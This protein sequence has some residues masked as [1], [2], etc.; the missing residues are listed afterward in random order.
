MGKKNLFSSEIKRLQNPSAYAIDRTFSVSD[1]NGRDR[2]LIEK[3]YIEMDAIAR[4]PEWDEYWSKRGLKEPDESTPNRKF[5]YN[6]KE[7]TYGSPGETTTLDISTT[8]KFVSLALEKVKAELTRRS[9]L[10]STISPDNLRYL[11]EKFSD[12]GDF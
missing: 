9:K 11:I 10:L 2:N 12:R 1:V 7:W 6:A 4:E 8:N 3:I 5:I